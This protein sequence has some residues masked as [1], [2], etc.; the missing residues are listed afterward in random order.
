MSHPDALTRKLAAE[1]LGT[2]ML[3]VSVIGSGIMAQTLSPDNTGVALL[4]NAIATGAMLYCIITVLG[5]VSGA[6]FNPAVTLAFRLRGEIKTAAALAFVAAQVA[7]GLIGVLITHAMFDQPL[8]QTSQTLHRTGSAQWVSE[9]C[10][11][12]GLLFVIFGGLR[13]R[14]D[15]VPTLVALYITGAYW[16]TA[17][18]SFA[19]PAVTIA[20]G[21]S[22]TFAGIYPAHI[23]AFIAA[24]LVA[25]LVFM[26]LLRR[27]LDE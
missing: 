16:F 14:P 25:V 4:A 11:T 17:S 2:A 23:P 15:A 7:G 10:A 22:D 1:A 5:P 8:L 24:Q 9:I 6:H 27:L 13:A 26:P 21:F 18:T 20:R 19:N 3:I 12:G